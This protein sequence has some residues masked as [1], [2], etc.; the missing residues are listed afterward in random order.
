MLANKL[1]RTRIY[2]NFH[3]ILERKP[4]ESEM[5]PQFS[6]EISTSEKKALLFISNKCSTIL[7][8]GHH[9]LYI[10]S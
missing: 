6:T 5:F 3:K 7:L 10:R 8:N 2:G 9:F 1:K 4:S